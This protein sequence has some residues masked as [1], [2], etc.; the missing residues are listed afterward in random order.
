[1][2]LMR[3]RHNRV[4][5]RLVK[6]VPQSLGDKFVEQKIKDSPGC[7]K[8]DLVILKQEEKRAYIVDVTIPFEGSEDAFSVASQ[9]K[10]DKYS[11]LQDWLTTKGYSEV[12]IHAFIIGSLGVRDVENEAV[13]RCLKIGR[14]IW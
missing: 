14:F 8:P 12:S 5:Q 1:M 9:E 13:L 4:L 10:I 6:A 11:P 2:G 3:E 7:L